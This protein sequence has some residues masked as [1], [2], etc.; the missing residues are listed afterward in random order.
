MKHS[1]QLEIQTQ[2]NDSSCGPTCLAAV[3][4]YWG[5]HVDLLSLI[6]KIGQLDGGGTLAVQLACD[7]LSRGYD[8]EITTYNL[9]LFDPTWFRVKVTD[10][11]DF[12]AGKLVAQL[13]AKRGRVG[14]DIHRLEHA[15]EAYLRF[16]SLGGQIR[17][18]ALD[19]ELI[20]ASLS[21]E[22]PILCG[23]SATYL[24]Q[25]AR[26]RAT[27]SIPGRTSVADDVAGDP[28]GHFVVLHGYDP[29]TGLVQLAD[30]LHPNP[31]APTNKYSAKLSR[32]L[33]AILLGIV[34][35]DANLLTLIPRTLREESPQ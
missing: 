14:V 15:T 4:Q 23:L 12:L 16:L 8:A 31:M 22:I 1:L 32:V 5:D 35:F 13:A 21:Q 34:T 24:Y 28:A 2:P 17:M 19:S 33:S 30:P 29:K 10:W 7:A 20:I 26:E 11:R 27:T 25:E 18:R 6:A 9:Q 3:Y